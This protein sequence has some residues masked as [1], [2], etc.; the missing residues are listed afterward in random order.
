YRWDVGKKER[1]V[2]FDQEEGLWHVS[3]LKDDGRLLLRRETGSLSAE[4]SEYDPPGK[5]L[6]PLLGQGEKEEYDARYGAREGTL[7]VLTNK[8]GEFRRLY[9]FSGGKLEPIGDEVKADVDAFDVDRRR[10]R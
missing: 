8:P 6:T 1:E 7:V 4:Y 5:R 10:T 2:V 9:A 3:D